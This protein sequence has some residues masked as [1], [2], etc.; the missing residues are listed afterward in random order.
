MLCKTETEFQYENRNQITVTIPYFELFIYS[1]T[2][3]VTNWARYSKFNVMYPSAYLSYTKLDDKTNLAGWFDR[4]S[5]KWCNVA[6][7][8]ALAWVQRAS[9]ASA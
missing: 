5:K 6:Y 2:Y 9:A 3:V 8:L 7:S 4:N 1:P